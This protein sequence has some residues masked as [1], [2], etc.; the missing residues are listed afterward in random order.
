M[1]LFENGFP[2]NAVGGLAIGVGAWLL[3]PVIVPVL[4]TVAR[5][6]AKAAIKGGMLLY[7]KGKELAAGTGEMMED[8]MAEVRTELG[9]GQKEAARG[10]TTQPA[11]G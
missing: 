9:E 11:E 2:G 3:A 7:E 6:A 8:L 10:A 1:A 4:A 5:P